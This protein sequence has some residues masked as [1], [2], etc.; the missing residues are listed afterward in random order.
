M[1]SYHQLLSPESR[2]RAP[3]ISSH[4]FNNVEGRALHR[5]LGTQE[6]AAEKASTP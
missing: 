6:W 5:V 4:L 2:G 3:P 1:M